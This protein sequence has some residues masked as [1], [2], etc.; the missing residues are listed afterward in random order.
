MKNLH[1]YFFPI[2]N[3]DFERNS[4]PATEIGHKKI[5]CQMKYLW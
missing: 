4:S 5:L 2:Q 3:N 1:F